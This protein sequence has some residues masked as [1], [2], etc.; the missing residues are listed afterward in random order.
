MTYGEDLW[1]QSPALFD[2]SRCLTE[3][4]SPELRDQFSNLSSESINEIKKYPCIFAYEKRAKKDA[5]IGYITNIEVRQTNVRIDFTLT[6]DKISFDDFIQLSELL[7]MDSWELNRTHWTIKKVCL[8]DLEPHFTTKSQHRPTVFVSY[9]WTPLSNQKKVATLISKLEQDGIIVR[10]DKK[11]LHPGQDINYFM[12]KSLSSGEIDN[13]IVVCNNDY[14]KKADSRQGGVGYEFELILNE[15]R[16][17]PLQ[18]KYIPVIV[19]KDGSG[20]MPLPHFLKSRLCIDLTQDAGYN[21][22]LN[23]I[24]HGKESD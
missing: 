24:L 1:E 10:Y 11:D 8:K 20:E 6:G 7:D 14:A 3:Y 17:A 4:I 16:N 12:E 18:T 19:D 13:V 15:I 23:A 2:K 5:A 21:E 9:C 22:L